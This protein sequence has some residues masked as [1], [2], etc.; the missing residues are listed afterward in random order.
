MCADESGGIVPIKVDIPLST[1]V[2]RGE[3]ADALLAV[4]ELVSSAV[5]ITLAEADEISGHA[6]EYIMR[7]TA[8]IHMIE[9][10]NS[11]E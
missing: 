6:R 8:V 11:G 2:T 10:L 3:L 9:K 7:Q 5:E 4:V 1:P